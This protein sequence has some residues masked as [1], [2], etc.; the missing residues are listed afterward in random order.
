MQKP[1]GKRDG[2][3]DRL[4]SGKAFFGIDTF[5]QHIVMHFCDSDHIAILRRQPEPGNACG[6]QVGHVFNEC[7]T[8]MRQCLHPIQGKERLAIECFD[9]QTVRLLG[10]N[11]LTIV[12]DVSFRACMGATR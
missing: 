4:Q 2:W 8:R 12:F 7:L 10:T 6:F 9:W 3:I 1:V 5:V 11:K